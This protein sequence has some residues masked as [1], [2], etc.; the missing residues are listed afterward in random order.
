MQAYAVKQTK[1][2]K[3]GGG[4]GATDILPFVALSFLLASKKWIM[5]VKSED[6]FLRFLDKIEN[7]VN[8]EA[9]GS[10]A[11]DIWEKPILEAM[12]ESSRK[13]LGY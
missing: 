12:P 6:A 1:Q 9:V 4:P 7:Y 2:I 5:E 11:I 10:T 3:F 13:T 8:L